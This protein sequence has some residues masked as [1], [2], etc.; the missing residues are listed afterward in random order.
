MSGFYN[1]M[2]KPKNPKSSSKSSSKSPTSPRSEYAKMMFEELIK[3]GIREENEVNRVI[4]MS[5]I[6][7]PIYEKYKK[8][9]KYFVDGISLKNLNFEYLALNP[10]LPNSLI[11]EIIELIGD[12]E[13]KLKDFYHNLAKNKNPK[14][15]SILRKIYNE[16]PDSDKLEWYDLSANPN[17]ISILKKEYERNPNRIDFN[18]LSSNTHRDA[19]K[20]LE[21]RIAVE[22][23]HLPYVLDTFKAHRKVIDWYFLSANPNAIKLIREEYKRNPV[24]NRIEFKELSKHPQISKL[25]DILIQKINFNKLDM[26]YL[27]SNPF[28]PRKLLDMI[29]R[30][31]VFEA[32]NPNL[33]VIELMREEYERDHKSQNIKWS[34]LSESKIPEAIT[35]LRDKIDRKRKEYKK[36]KN[37]TY[38]RSNISIYDQL[39]FTRLSA[40]P[41]DEAVSLLK[42]YVDIELGSTSPVYIYNVDTGLFD[43][44]NVDW[45]ALSG[46]PHPEAIKLLKEKIVKEKKL[47]YDIRHKAKTGKDRINWDKISANTGAIELIIEKLRNETSV[48]IS[49]YDT[50]YRINKDEL[51]TNPAIFVDYDIPK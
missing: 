39:D 11:K 19:I 6:L 4:S 3:K 32:D 40:N 50:I 16:N 9:L 7:L 17:A 14:V 27:A 48:P 51:S 45:D 38:K 22:N 41:T 33:Y 12:D 31:K 1:W 46:N 23:L 18:A 21:R 36:E 37:T 26:R 5:E 35:L 47:T 43:E 42:E 20:L 49:V 24:S 29:D 10:R 28:A 2:G 25:T 13:E 44:S 34:P 30:K 8:S 15:F